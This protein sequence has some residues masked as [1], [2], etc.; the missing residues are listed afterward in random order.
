MKSYKEL[1]KLINEV[2][3]TVGSGYRVSPL[4]G[5]S[6]AMD[7]DINLSSLSNVAV[8]RINAYLGAMAAKPYINP[9]EALKQAQ[10]RLQMV[11]LDF[12]MVKDCEMRLKEEEG[13]SFPLTRFGG[14]FGVDGTSYDYKSDD[15]IT[16]KLGHGLSLHVRTH[17]LPNG[18][19]QVEAQIV[20]TL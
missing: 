5:D 19:T 1:R 10:G 6:N 20:P 4:N 14:G 15:G 11:G 2:T 17:P 3:V 7:N 16:P 18:L 12:Q 13:M 9:M 8:S